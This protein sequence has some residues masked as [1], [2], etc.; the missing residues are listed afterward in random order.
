[1][2]EN[3]FQWNKLRTKI[4]NNKKNMFT[5]KRNNLQ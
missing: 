4:D 5:V 1:M 2:R 3:D